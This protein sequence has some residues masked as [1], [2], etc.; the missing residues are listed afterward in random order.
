MFAP[1]QTYASLAA[2]PEGTA[3]AA[4][5]ALPARQ[6]HARV[7]WQLAPAMPEPGLLEVLPGCESASS[8][9]APA[10]P[11]RVESGSSRDRVSRQQATLP[12][13]CRPERLSRAR[14]PVAR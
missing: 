5:R 13:R 8:P 1:A 2:P 4:P 3:R 10:P 14:P 11:L 7:R 9:E 12:L 6:L